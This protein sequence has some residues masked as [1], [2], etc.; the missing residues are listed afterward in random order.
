M[1]KLFMLI[2]TVTATILCRAQGMPEDGGTYY[3]YCDNDQPQYFFNETGY[4]SVS[5]TCSEGSPAYLWNVTKSGDAYILQSAS[6]SNCYFGFKGMVDHPYEW[7]ISSDKAFVSGNVTLFGAY[8]GRNIYMVMKNTG[9]FD[10]ATGVFNKETTDFSSDYCFVPYQ[11][12]GI[13][14]NIECNLP[15]ARGVF[16]LEGGGTKRGDCTFYYVAGAAE[17][18]RLSGTSDN[19]AYQFK[20]FYLNGENLGKVVNV[21]GLGSVTLQAIFSLDIFSQSYGEK[22]IR[23]GTAEDANS[24]ARSNG[25]DTPMH[26]RLDISDEAYLWCFV[27]NANDYVI[28]NRAMGRDVALTADGTADGDATYFTSAGQARHWILLDTYETA[29]SGAGY[30][31]TLSGTESQGINSYGGATGWPIKFWRA[32]GAG[33]HWNFER[34]SER[35][36]TYRL[37]GTNPY[38]GTNTKVADFDVTYGSTTFRKSLTNRNEVQQD[39]LFL[40]SNDQVVIRETEHYRGYILDGMEYQDDGN[41]V[42]NIQADPDNKY[43]YLYYSNSPEGYPYRIPAIVNTR[44]NVLLAINDYRPGGSDIGYG[45]VDIMLRR[46]FDNGR[47]WDAPRCI[48]DGIPSS[49]T[50]YPYFGYGYGDAAVV[51]DRGSDEVLL[52]CV[53]GRVPYPSATASSRPCVTRMRSHDGG[54]TWTTPENITAQ[55]F[56]SEGALLTDSSR[57]IDCYGGFFGSGKILQSRIIKRGD[58]YRLYGAMLCRGKNVAGAYVFYSDDFGQTWNLLSPNTV[59]AIPGSDEPKVEELPNGNIALSGRKSYGRYFNVFHFDDETF[60]TGSWGNALQSNQQENG[61]SVGS[62]SCNGELLIVYGKRADGQYPN[63]VYPIALQSIPWGNDR[64]NVGI[65]W[66]PLSFNTTY[67]YTSELFSRNWNQGLQVSDR[68]SAYSTMC[69]QGDNRIAF[70][71][72]EGP[73]AYCMVYVPLTLEEITNGQYRMYDPSDG[74][75]DIEGFEPVQQAPATYDLSGR[76]VSHVIQPGI[77]IRGGKKFTVK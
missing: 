46:S 16:T 12:E 38:P 29:S 42:V 57:D 67:N 35:N 64:S 53:G 22:W 2:F 68:S 24:A 20:G 75:M 14:I 77:Y 40:P 62:N 76:R 11:K 33:T 10:Q 23:F 32:S 13:P 50:S 4:L 58:Y 61:I 60:T 26:T 7:T 69:V 55:F 54:E 45:E 49:A 36:V 65:W 71:Y 17:T 34:V 9:A 19:A 3:I 48:A 43:Q 18:V 63:N 56:G 66:K 6:D 41:I 31:I 27:G 70:F 5:N 25:N 52:L 1:K 44:N 21:D 59:E 74:I 72:E 39:V 51:A 15:Q 28:Y 37:T 73:N 30:V 47:T 8:N